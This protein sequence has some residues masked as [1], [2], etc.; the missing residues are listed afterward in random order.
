MKKTFLQAEWRKLIMANYRVDPQVLLPFVPDGTELDLWNGTCYVSLIGFLFQNTRVKGIR[1][2]FHTN[3]EEVNLRF[4][5]KRQENGVTQR[6]VVFLKEIVPRLA[7]SLVANT[8]YGEHYETRSMRHSWQATPTALEVSYA[9]KQKNWHSL[10]VTADPRPVPIA[11]GSEEEFITEHFWGFTRLGAGQTSAYEV[12]HPRWEL[13]PVREYTVEV[14]FEAVY[15]P[16]FGFLNQT[17]P[18]SVFLAEGSE[19]LV[20][21]GGRLSNP[22]TV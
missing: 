2:P 13:Y 9:W 22:L 19:I 18:V 21:G 17:E 12:A 15:G 10:R 1:V 3:F 6:G 5:V 11:V 20:K 7:I 16:A 4:Y 8:L 14:D